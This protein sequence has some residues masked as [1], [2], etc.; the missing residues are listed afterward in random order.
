M[1]KFETSLNYPDGFFHCDTI[2]VEELGRNNDVDEDKINEYIEECIKYLKEN[3]AED[4]YTIQTGN[5]MVMAERG[6]E[7][8]QVTVMKNYWQKELPLDLEIVK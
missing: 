1:I 8:F 2:F 3:L 4:Y 7:S 5:T 6:D